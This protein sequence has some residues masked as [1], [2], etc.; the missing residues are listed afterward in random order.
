[1]NQIFV[2]Q[3]KANFVICNATSQGNP[4]IRNRENGAP[5]IQSFCK[6]MNKYESICVYKDR[7]NY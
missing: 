4:A 7:K 6:I 3:K 5:F 1:M 2:D